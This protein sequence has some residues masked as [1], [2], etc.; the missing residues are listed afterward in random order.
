LIRLSAIR[1][2]ASETNALSGYSRE[3][4]EKRRRVGVD[5]TG[6]IVAYA[7]T[8]ATVDDGRRAD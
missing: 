7:L 4:C 8:D 2:R 6:A 3:N 5:Q 1:K